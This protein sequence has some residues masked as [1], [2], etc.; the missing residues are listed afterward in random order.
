[1][2]IFGNTAAGFSKEVDNAMSTFKSTITKLKATAEKAV[3]TKAEKAVATK[4]EKQDE[5]KKLESECSALDGVSTK[6]NNLAAKL[7]ALFE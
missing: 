3:A 1:M 2:N 6:A 5:I 7:E 4:A